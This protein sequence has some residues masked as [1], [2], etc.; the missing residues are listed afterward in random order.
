MRLTIATALALTALVTPA[1]AHP[2]VGTAAGFEAGFLHPMHGLDHV[3][4]TV[5]VGFWAALTGGVARWAWP[6]AFVTAMMLA[7]LAGSTGVPVPGVEAWVAVSVIV[8]GT[9]VA[10]RPALP[11]AVG[12]GL[13]GLLA[14]AHGY[15]HGAEIPAG[16]GALR[17]GLGFA[18]ATVLLN[19]LGLGGGLML[20][21][22]DRTWT[23]A[24]AGG[25]LAATGLV[26][27]L[28]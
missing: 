20:A 21:R 1:L 27:A 22:F 4:A 9:A 25:A 13:T 7:A 16:A 3:L 5:A 18:L 11:V 14:L 6:A 17:Y 8:L 24:L 15:V 23:P 19:G 26:L 10:R 2:G 28:G 12:A